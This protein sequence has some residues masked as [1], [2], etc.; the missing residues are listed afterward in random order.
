MS[1]SRERKQESMADIILLV[2]RY[3]GLMNEWLKDFFNVDK[4]KN[5]SRHNSKAFFSIIE[6]IN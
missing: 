4:K 2:L 5:W 6:L 1:L 3:F